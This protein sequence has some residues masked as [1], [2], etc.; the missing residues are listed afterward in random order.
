MGTLN[1]GMGSRDML[2]AIIMAQ[3]AASAPGSSSINSQG[4]IGQRN[5]VSQKKRR[6][7]NRQ[8]GIYP[9]RH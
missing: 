3:L 7:L 1:R 2:A 5:Q 4:F 9:N 6:K 8:T